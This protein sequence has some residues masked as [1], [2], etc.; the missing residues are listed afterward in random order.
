MLPCEVC[1]VCVC[2]LV[3]C[4]YSVLSLSCRAREEGSWWCCVAEGK[5]LISNHLPSRYCLPFLFPSPSFD[6]YRCCLSLSPP[7]SVIP[8]PLSF[9]VLSLPSPFSVLPPF[10]L[11]LFSLS[12]SL[13]LISYQYIKNITTYQ[14]ILSITL[15]QYAIH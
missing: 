3:C 14:L 1:F 15:H 12:H 8:P 10:L 13:L 2:L 7:L 5:D 6:Y 11:F 9:S 4:W